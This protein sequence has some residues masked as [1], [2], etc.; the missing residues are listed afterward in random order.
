MNSLRKLAALTIAAAGIVV[1]LHANAKTPDTIACNVV[2]DYSINRVLRV[3]FSQS[4]TVAPGADFDYDF[5]SATRFRYFQARADVDATTGDTSVM[6]NY[7]NDV[8]VFTFVEAGTVVRVRNNNDV[9]TSAGKST[10]FT[11]Q[12][13]AGEHTT[14]YELSC[15]VL[16]K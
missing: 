12:G 15:A 5:S 9:F 6:I 2:I 11:S 13:T 1:P 10:F 16:R 8:G 4:F 7:Y 14:E 3:P